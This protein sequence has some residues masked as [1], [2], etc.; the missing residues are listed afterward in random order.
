MLCFNEL[1][2]IYGKKLTKISETFLHSAAG[3]YLPVA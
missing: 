3:F 1:F 2:K